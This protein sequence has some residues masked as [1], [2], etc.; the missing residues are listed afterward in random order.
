MTREPTA[1]LAL[2][3]LVVHGAR[4]EVKLSGNRQR[5][6]LTMLLLECNRVVAVD[7]LIRAIWGDSPPATARSQIR[8]CVSSLRRQFDAGDVAATIETHKTGYR[9][10]T[11]DTGVD[12]HRF[13]QLISRARAGAAEHPD[14]DLALL[15]REA[16]ALWR[17]PLG[18][19]LGSPL[20]DTVALKYHEDYHS[21][22]ED[23]YE[24]ELRLGYHRR[25]LGELTHHVS[26][27]PFRETLIA[28][29]MIAL[30]R[31]G[32]TADALALFRD[33]HRRFRD[34][35]GIVPGERLQ[36]IESLILG[37]TDKPVAQQPR[38]DEVLLFGAGAADR[39]TDRAAARTTSPATRR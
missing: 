12:L 32:R 33:T 22:L 15:Y 10:R 30:Y 17:G 35:L 1:F 37:A 29:L 27:H 34:E 31:S 38:T 21:A 5:I 18:E 14:L 16:L 24:L 13:G 6:L 39:A 8:I 4:G 7:R 28:Q 20:L 11:P 25:V 9:L 19:G 3:A 23:C 26:E 36:S 2:G